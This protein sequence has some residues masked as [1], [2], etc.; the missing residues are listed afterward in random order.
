MNTDSSVL[1]FV[2]RIVALA[3]CLASSSLSAQAQS[4]QTLFEAARGFDAAYLATRSQTDSAQYRTQQTYALKRPSANLSGTLGRAYTDPPPS[5]LNPTGAHVNTSTSG[6]TVNGR[7][8]LVNRQSDV[9]ID[10]A[11]KGLEIAQTD[12]AIAEQDLIVRLAQAY[13]D[14]L[15][16]QDVLAAAQ[17]SEKAIAEQLASAKRNFE[18]G[19]AT[20]TDAREAQARADLVAAQKIAAE[21]DLRVKRLALDQL[22]GQ[23]DVKPN[24]LAAP[25]SLPPVSPDAMDP[26]VAQAEGQHPAARRSALALDVAKLE[27]QKARAG[28]WPTV[29]LVGNV[30][31]NRAINNGQGGTTTTASVGVQLAMP[32][33]AGYA[34]ENRVKESLLLEEKAVNDWANVRRTLAQSARASYLGVQSGRAQVNALEAAEASSRLALE[35]TQTGYRVGVRVNVDVLN[36]QTQL[37]QTQRDLAIARY[38]VLLGTLRLKQAAGQL[39]AADLAAMDALL[40]KAP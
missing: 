37:F 19:T 5:A 28:H 2:W 33:F 8:P 36:A 38:N 32:L 14:V 29:D 26:W 31:P 7:Q 6:V 21:N 40:I 23:S 35:A 17:A 22:V 15:G 12:L 9:T 25:V 18:V 10:Q 13:F 27:T 34:I 11:D 16:A 30:G 39:N 4:L 24:R 20:I 3:A 1:P